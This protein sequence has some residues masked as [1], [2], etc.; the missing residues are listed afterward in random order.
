MIHGANFVRTISRAILVLASGFL[1]LT[2]SLFRTR[3]ALAYAGSSHYHE[4]FVKHIVFEQFHVTATEVR[5]AMEYVQDANQRFPGSTEVVG[6]S[7]NDTP[8]S[9]SYCYDSGFLNGWEQKKCEYYLVHSAP[10]TE[11]I[12]TQGEFYYDG[13]YAHYQQHAFFKALNDDRVEYSCYF[14]FGTL[15]FYWTSEC[16]GGLTK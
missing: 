16:Y 12:D 7:Y 9:D 8:D 13:G 11:E 14:D 3:D 10:Y 6:G 4:G 2:V 1:V 5:V 15:P